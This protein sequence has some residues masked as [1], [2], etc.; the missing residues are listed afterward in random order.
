M[1]LADLKSRPFQPLIGEYPWLV[2]EGPPHW[3][4]DPRGRARDAGPSP[5][6][7]PSQAV[8]VG[9][10]SQA[11]RGRGV[12]AEQEAG[13]GGLRLLAVAFTCCWWPPGSQ[14][15]TLRGSFSS[16]AARDAQGQSIGHFEFHGR[17]GGGERDE[18]SWAH[19]AAPRSPP[20]VGSREPAAARL[21]T[22]PSSPALTA[23]PAASP[24]VASRNRG[25]R[26]WPAPV[27]LLPRSLYLPRL[28][29]VFCT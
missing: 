11:V 16:A 14:G 19:P 10:R 17:C 3:L 2:G 18:G 15:K 9:S 7:S 5:L 23:W 6:T 28:V 25:M 4:L 12:S 27:L 29:A 24:I 26:L 1:G 20:R 13:M 8:D 22:S 21:G